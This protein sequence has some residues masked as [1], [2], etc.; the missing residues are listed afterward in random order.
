MKYDKYQEQII[1]TNDKFIIVVAGA[2]TG[3][4]ALIKG[5]VDYLINNQNIN[6]E[7]ITVLSYTNKAVKELKERIEK[8]VNICTIHSLA[9]QIC[10][11]EIKNITIVGES[12]L[13]E[14]IENYLQNNKKIIKKYFSNLEYL[15]NLIYKIITINKQINP[16]SKK[17]KLIINIKNEIE[18]KYQNQKQ[19]NNLFDYQDLLI[20]ATKILQEN[21]TNLNIKYLL[22]DEYQDLSNL[23]YQLIKIIQKKTNSSMLVVGDDAQS[24]YAFNGSNLNIFYQFSNDFINAK[25]FYLK[26]TYRFSQQLINITTALL[27]KNQNQLKKDLISDKSL[28]KP[29]K[30]YYYYSLTKKIKILEKIIKKIDVNKKILI[31]GRYNFDINFIKINKTFIYNKKTEK[32]K[33]P[34]NPL[35]DITF[36]TI[37]SS[38][39]L[40]Y[41]E[42]IIINNEKTTYGFPSNI[43]KDNILKENKKKITEEERRLFYVALTRTK[44]HVYLLVNLFK[45]SIFIKELKKIVNKK[46][47]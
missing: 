36:M 4:T 20:F 27:T 32:I 22:I 25:T 45:P 16:K 11:K 14:I 40:G 18:I 35:Y 21:K 3:K 19:K 6:P 29:I 46:Q 41:D 8:N 2:G 33:Y 13:K 31:L 23:K 5:K 10:K 1:K 34:K 37:H 24:I 7:S 47:N 12:Y 9:Y 43:T 30:F 15:K 44:N 28:K 42:V 38:K 26:K 39:G 17:S